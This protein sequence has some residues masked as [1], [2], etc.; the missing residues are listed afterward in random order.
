MQLFLHFV[1]D[2]WLL[3]SVLSILIALLMYHEGRKSGPTVTPQQL[4]T[5]VNRQNAVVLDIR[6][7]KDFR[8]GHVI[9]AVNIPYDQLSQQLGQLESSRSRPVVV[10][11]K[12]GQQAG[13]AAKLLKEKGFEQIYRLAGG[14]MEWRN[15][16]LPLV[17]E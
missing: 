2:Q 6:A 11:C 8:S 4:S 17:K 1:S 14:M 13:A 7:Q 5:L 9:D 15:S 10:V 12:T 16:Q 3:F